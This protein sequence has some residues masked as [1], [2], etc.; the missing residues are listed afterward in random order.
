[1]LN[2]ARSQILRLEKNYTSKGYAEIDFEDQKILL[3]EYAVDGFGNDSDLEKRNS[4]EDLM[5]EVLGWTGLGHCDG[6]SIGSGSM[7]VCCFVVDFQLAQH[8]IADR[9]RDT[10]FADYTRIYQEN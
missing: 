1:M 10:E 2:S 4:L 6:G 7:E 8:V 5:N 9:L 3:I